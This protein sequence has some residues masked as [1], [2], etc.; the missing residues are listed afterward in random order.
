MTRNNCD[1]K[2]SREQFIE[3]EITQN[4]QI[5]RNATKYIES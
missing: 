4:H 1:I 3:T 2:V 5:L